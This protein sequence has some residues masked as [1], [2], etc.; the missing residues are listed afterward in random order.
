MTE[1]V[2]KPLNA[3]ALQKAEQNNKT[4]TKLL[5]LI[6]IQDPL[7]DTKIKLL[8]TS[9]LDFSNT[10][11]A[12]ITGYVITT[13]QSK[14]IKNWDDVITLAAKTKLELINIQCPWSRIYYINNVSYNKKVQS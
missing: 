3:E 9:K 14:K 4:T 7:E 5:Y 11:L 12:T 6:V 2:V 1:I 10:I 13:A 8:V